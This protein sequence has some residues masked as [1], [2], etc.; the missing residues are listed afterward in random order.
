MKPTGKLIYILV[1]LVLL[2]S[3][4]IPT[5]VQAAQKIEHDA[6]DAILLMAASHRMLDS[7]VAYS[8]VP[9]TAA[10]FPQSNAN[11]VDILIDIYSQQIDRARQMGYGDQLEARLLDELE[12][13]VFNLQQK[14]QAVEAERNSRRRRGFFRRFFRS[15]GRGVGWVMGKVME[16]GG[17]VVQFGIEEVAPQMIKGAVFGGSPLTAAAFRATFRQMLRKRI[18]EVIIRKVENRAA[19]LQAESEHELMANS[20]V[21]E[22]TAASS[23]PIIQ[24]TTE[25]Q[26]LESAPTCP[27]FEVVRVD[28]RNNHPA[29]PDVVVYANSEAVAPPTG[30]QVSYSPHPASLAVNTYWRLLWKVGSRV[31]ASTTE[32]V[33]CA[34]VFLVGHDI[35]PNEIYLNGELISNSVTYAQ[36][37]I[38]R[39]PRVTGF[40]YIRAAVDPPGPATITVV[41]LKEGAVPVYFFGFDLP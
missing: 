38:D 35:T 17:K 27:P 2:S 26:L 23:A 25:N 39:D 21:P 22:S 8:G 41:A 14:A 1:I 36:E 19:A 20:D 28:I 12:A 4:V 18:E 31:E 33:T 30:F 32:T 3:S 15:L 7:E 40:F 29:Y 10:I 37:P 24:P 9:K 6:D 16:G 5:K 13:K 11:E 34:G